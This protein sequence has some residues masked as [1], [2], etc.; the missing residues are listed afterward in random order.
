MS[1]PLVAWNQSARLIDKGLTDAEGA[2]K[3]LDEESL[4]N[5]WALTVDTKPYYV[6]EAFRGPMWEEG[7]EPSIAP[8][9]SPSVSPSDS[10]AEPTE[11]EP[12]PDGPGK[13][14]VW[15]VILIVLGALLLAAAAA[16]LILLIVRRKRTAGTEKDED[17]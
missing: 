14:P 15:V 16:V 1:N 4:A 5:N 8:T 10:P 17:I 7:G 12:F 3:A 9:D 13:P 11:R 2:F 6:N